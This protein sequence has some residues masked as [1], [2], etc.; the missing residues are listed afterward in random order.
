[1]KPFILYMCNTYVCIFSHFF[2]NNVMALCT[3]FYNI[4]EDHKALTGKIQHICS[5]LPIFRNLW[6][7]F[8]LT[9]I[10]QNRRLCRLPWKPYFV[11]VY[12]VLALE[13]ICNTRFFCTEFFSNNMLSNS[14][15]YCSE[16][17]H[18]IYS[19]V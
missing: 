6:I 1:M 19:H 11:I 10:E 5:V 14:F 7:Y 17:F 12:K 4:V 9:F 2:N 13:Q 8:Y 16:I 18:V 15:F 3:R